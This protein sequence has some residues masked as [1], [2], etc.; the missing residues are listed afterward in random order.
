MSCGISKLEK[1]I[2]QFGHA[3]RTL[4]DLPVYVWRRNKK[5]LR[6]MTRQLEDMQDKIYSMYLTIESIYGVRAADTG[7]PLL[8]ERKF[9]KEIKER[10]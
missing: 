1:A 5:E 3:D 4:R 6:T 9:K 10:R 2:L 7:K 8:V